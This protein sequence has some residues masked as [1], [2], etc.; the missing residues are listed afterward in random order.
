[1]R[2]NIFLLLAVPTMFKTGYIL[3]LRNDLFWFLL[4]LE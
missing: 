1:M 4:S 3:S 2:P